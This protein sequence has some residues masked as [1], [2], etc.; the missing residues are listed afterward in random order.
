MVLEVGTQFKS[1]EELKRACQ[2]L[3]TRQNFEYSVLKSDRSRLILKCIGEGCPWRLHASKVVDGDDSSFQVKTLHAEHNCLG[4]HH[5]GH[6]QAS[7][8]FI[9]EQIQAKVNDTS[10]YRPVSIKHD[11]RREYG[12]QLTYKQ[13]HRAKQRAL[14][15]INGTEEE[16]FAAMSKYCED[17]KRNNPGSTIVFECTEEEG[18]QSRFSRVFI[19]YGASAIGF[20]FCC[21]VLG[22]D[23]THL[24]S[25]YKGT[26]MTFAANNT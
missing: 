23:G 5:L 22:L 19:C 18:N 16:S 3:A 10:S 24:K 15:A 2:T 12:I 21:P 9:G 25:K 7:A 14:Q 11:I 6:R 8:K 4:V 1:K 17:L 26:I 13:A 20:G